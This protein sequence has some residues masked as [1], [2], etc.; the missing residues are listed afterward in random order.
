MA[1]P[2]PLGG[3]LTNTQPVDVEVSNDLLL[4]DSSHILL[5]RGLWAM[6]SGFK[7]SVKALNHVRGSRELRIPNDSGEMLRCLLHGCEFS[8]SM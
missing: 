1:S 8:Y 3:C 2:S 7:S 6:H 4:L 5:N